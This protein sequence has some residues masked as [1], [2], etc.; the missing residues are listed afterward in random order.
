MQQ[1]AHRPNANTVRET[2]NRHRIRTDS[3]NTYRK[4][5]CREQSKNA[6]RMV[7]NRYWVGLEYCLTLE[8][9]DFE[10]F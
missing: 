2:L 7:E 5:V 9:E 3:N 6:R 4:A 10:V 1:E 8:T